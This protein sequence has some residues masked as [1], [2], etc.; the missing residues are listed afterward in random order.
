MVREALVPISPARQTLAAA[1]PHQRFNVLQG[2]IFGL[3]HKQPCERCFGANAISARKAKGCRF[4]DLVEDQGKE[5]NDERIGD[6]L[7]KAPVR[8][9]LCPGRGWEYLRHEVPEG[10][11]NA[12]GKNTRKQQNEASTITP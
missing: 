6:P 12:R 7:G 8:S 11:T 5:K 4:A 2:H 9:W 10:G 1:P 3:R